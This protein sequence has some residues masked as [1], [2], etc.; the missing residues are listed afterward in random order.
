MNDIPWISVTEK[1]PEINQECWTFDGKGVHFDKYC[2]IEDDVPEGV[3]PDAKDLFFRE[4]YTG[5][6]LYWKPVIFFDLLSE[7]SPSFP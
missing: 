3:V 4:T 2:Y 5:S 7:E 6:V 1:M